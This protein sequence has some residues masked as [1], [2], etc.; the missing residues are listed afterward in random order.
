MRLKKKPV[1]GERFVRIVLKIA[2]GC[3]DKVE[4]SRTVSDR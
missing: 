2:K 3:N 1:G 4:K